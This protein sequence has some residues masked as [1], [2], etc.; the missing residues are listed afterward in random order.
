MR[1]IIS[2]ILVISFSPLFGQETFNMTVLSNWTVDTLATTNGGRKFNDCWGYV[3]CSGNEYAIVGSASRVHFFDL[4]DPS[5]PEEL[6]SFAGGYISTW[7]DMKTFRDRAYAVTDSKP[8]GLMIFDLSNI[9]DTIIKTN[10]DSSFFKESH[11]IFID[12]DHGRLYSVGMDISANMTILDL[13]GDPDNP[14]L[15]ANVNLAGGGYVHDVY[16]KD[17]IAYCSHGNN[18]LYIW[19]LTDP[20][21]PVLLGSAVTGA[22]NH[23][24]WL[25]EDGQY[26]I[27]AEEVPL[28]RPLGILDVSDP[29]EIEIINTFKFPLLAPEHENNVPHNPFI[30]DHYAIV[31]HYH[32]GLQVF[33]IADPLN[34]VQVAWVDTYENETYNGYQGNWGV[35]PFLPSGNIIMTDISSGLYVLSL[36]NIDF[37]NNSFTSTPSIEVYTNGNSNINPTICQNEELYIFA[38]SPDANSFQWYKNNEP[39]PGELSDQIIIVESGVYT[40]EA[41]NGHCSSF[42][43]SVE[44]VVMELPFA[45]IVITDSIFCEGLSYELSSNTLADNYEWYLNGQPLALDSMVMIST[46][47]EYQLITNIAG[48]ENESPILPI[49][50]SLQPEP[51]FENGNEMTICPG[52]TVELSLTED[53]ESYGW[54]L[55]GQVL[56]D[57]IQLEISNPGIYGVIVSDGTCEAE[58]APF[59]LNNFDI[60]TP[61]IIWNGINLVASNENS[62]Q[63]FFEGEL[64]PEATTMTFTPEMEGNFSVEIIDE[65]GC[66]VIS[67]DFQFIF[68]DVNEL[69]NLPTILVSPNPVRD[70]L[71][72]KNANDKSKIESIQIFDELGQKIREHQLESASNPISLSMEDLIDGIYF[73]QIHIKGGSSKMIKIVKMN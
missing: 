21:N 66:T 47:G 20:T 37:S 44:V 2:L 30:R 45:D 68:S 24:S 29:E 1:V 32:D 60:T 50:F 11:N 59:V 43:N 69:L 16:V 39:I 38:T 41:I 31:S 14:T 62:Y 12:T 9:Q 15:L 63:W 17:H 71:L 23:S 73:V 19:D 26:V 57:S 40:V 51:I 34:P 58:S 3:D 4:S 33:D 8:E 36:D 61:S 42:S 48:C 46:S 52:E 10:Q 72:V 22:Y 28:G 67:E 27:Y 64:I 25:T 56:D 53:F 55:D 65:N 7:R 13:N 70:E 35:Y 6:A 5:Q 18:G 54:M 49:T